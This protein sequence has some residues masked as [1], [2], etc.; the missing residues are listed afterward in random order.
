MYT[1]GPQLAFLVGFVLT[2]QFPPACS[3]SDL[4]TWMSHRCESSV[5]RWTGYNEKT[6]SS[7]FL[8][9]ERINFHKVPQVCQLCSPDEGLTVIPVSILKPPAAARYPIS[10]GNCVT[11][12]ACVCLY[13]FMFVCMHV[14]LCL[15]AFCAS[16]RIQLTHSSWMESVL[17][18]RPCCLNYWVCQDCEGKQERK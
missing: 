11:A 7:Q 13:T 2:L 1:D 18:R 9:R 5:Q 10:K 8:F 3:L 12:C 16:K 4:E 14:H 6:K 15:C 17:W